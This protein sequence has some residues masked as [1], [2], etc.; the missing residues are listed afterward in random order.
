MS[1]V[2]NNAEE[3][4]K[5]LTENLEN[6][7]KKRRGV[8]SDDAKAWLCA[9]EVFFSM[10]LS[11]TLYEKKIKEIFRSTATLGYGVENSINLLLKQCAKELRQCEDDIK[12]KE[13][14]LTTSQKETKLSYEKV[15]IVHGHNGELKLRVASLIRQQGIKAVI[16]DEQ[17]NAGRT[18]IEKFEKNS[19]VGGA[20]CLFTA[21]DIG[22]KKGETGEGKCRPRQNVVFEA[23]YF[24][25]KLGR[26]HVVI[27]SDSGVE[28]PSDMSGI[29]YTNTQNWEVNMLRELK[30][31]GY[32][33]DMNKLFEE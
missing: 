31:M 12:E 16:L 29:V 8:Y 28:L 32:S 1:V 26:N 24:M 10:Y 27:I 3:M 6:L 14:V 7:V 2:E 30:A 17:V 4:L 15:F 9:L 25:G 13:K 21:D 5:E 33:I 11:D 20:I 23:G 22:K 19:D 18:I